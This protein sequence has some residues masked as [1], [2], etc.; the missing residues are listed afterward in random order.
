MLGARRVFVATAE[1]LDAEMRERIAQHRQ[2][3]G[4]D[5]QTVEEP[6]ALPEAISSLRDVDVVVFDCLTLWL[7]NLLLRHESSQ[8]IL[9]RVDELTEVIRRRTFHCIVVTNEVGMGVVPET[10]LGRAFRD[11]AGLAHQRIARCADEVYVA[12]LGSVL[13]IRPAPVEV[14]PMGG[15]HADLK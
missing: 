1:A 7:S 5:F 12:I 2:E 14:Q 13:R 15:S 4:D 6:I 8:R 9:Q 3:R 10:P 11:L